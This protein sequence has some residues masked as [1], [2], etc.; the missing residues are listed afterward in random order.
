M[1]ALRGIVVSSS[2][3]AILYCLSSAA[4]CLTWRR[5]A[6][7]AQRRPVGRVADLLFAWRMLP[8]LFA[9]VVTLLFTVPSFLLLEPRAIREPLGLIPVITGLAGILLALYG[10]AHALRA[11]F[12][13]SRAIAQWTAG[14]QPMNTPS[15]V[16]VL[17]VSA[18][19]PAMT[20]AGIA[21]S[22]V[23]LSNAAES[24]MSSGEFRA[25]LNHELAH[26]R[27]RDNLKKLML[28]F[29]AF[30]G[31]RNLESS[32]L[33]ASEMAADDAAVASLREALDLAAALIKASR[34][35]PV[36][37]PVELTASLVRHPAG[38][39]SARIERLIAWTDD[40]RPT[41]PKL[42]RQS[43]YAPAAS[44]AVFAVF[45]AHYG[46]MLARIHQA[47]EWLVR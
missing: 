46:Q 27:R 34:L 8:V 10:A 36:A 30:P 15:S 37:A 6:R 3:F 25:A 32:W 33:Q 44:L 1:F 43:L 41:P 21:R 40:R 28:Q 4:V 11:L 35:S 18:A 7:Y 17:R 39:M 13:A 16:P 29:V 22:R 23:L 47:T 20:A 24:V 12:L 45:V 5:I 26:V 14:A 38:M 19:A 2:V 31:M 42:S 9:A